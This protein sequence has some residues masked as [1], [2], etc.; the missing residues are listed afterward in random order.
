MNLP[1]PKPGIIDVAPYV[2]G[3]HSVEGFKDVVLL[4]SNETPLGASQSAITAYKKEAESMH[5]YCDGNAE[6]LRNTIGRRFRCNPDRIVCGAGSDEIIQNLIRS[7]SGPG[8]ELIYSKHGFSIYPIFATGAGVTPVAANDTEFTANTD[9]LLLK[10]TDRTR[11]VF[12][13]NP[14][15]PTGTYISEETLTK[16]RKELRKDIL[17]VLDGAYAEYVTRADYRAGIELVEQNENVVMTRTCSKIFGLAALRLGWAYC[18]PAVADILNRIRS[19][20]NVN[21]PAQAAGIAAMED[22][23]HTE[24]SLAHNEKWL[25]W[26]TDRLTDLGLYTTSSAANFVLTRFC[27]EDTAK[28]VYQGLLDKGIITRYLASYHLPDCLRI[29]VGLDKDNKAV[30]DAIREI[31]REKND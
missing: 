4:A 10:V 21:G 16:F 15:N 2:G 20:F 25:P 5:R 23:A 26:L 24:R 18:P 8:D 12:L 30:I 31:V 19:P 29:S 17:L 1:R 27:N 22:T 9:E 13:A 28:T 3:Q 14:N 6:D 11:L 7:Y